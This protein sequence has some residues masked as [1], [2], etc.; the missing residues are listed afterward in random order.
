MVVPSSDN[1]FSFSL[2]FNLKSRSHLSLPFI[3][4]LSLISLFLSVLD[5]GVWCFSC[6]LVSISDLGLWYF[7]CYLISLVLDCGCDL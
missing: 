2:S 4:D 6:Y 7:W 3:S 1:F 5:L